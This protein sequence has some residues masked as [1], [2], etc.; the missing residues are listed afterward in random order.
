MIFKKYD[1]TENNRIDTSGHWINS[2]NL[3][4]SGVLQVQL[5][6][7]LGVSISNVINNNSSFITN[8]TWGTTATE[9]TIK[10]NSN[11]LVDAQNGQNSYHIFS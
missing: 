3:T 10:T 8:T 7:L 11:V 6:R 2:N 5:L 9:K 1:G 4:V